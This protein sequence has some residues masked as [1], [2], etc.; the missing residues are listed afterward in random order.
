MT[1]K[2]DQLELRRQA[3]LLKI[4]AQ[5]QVLALQLQ[6]MKQSANIAELGYRFVSGVIGKLRKNPVLGV[7]IGAGMLLIKPTRITSISK[8]AF[9]TWQIWRVIAPVINQFKSNAKK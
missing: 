4:S 5:R 8:T 7:A 2:P 3:L 6:D 1:T 9:K